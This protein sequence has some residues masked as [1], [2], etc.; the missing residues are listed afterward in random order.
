MKKFLIM[1]ILAAGFASAQEMKE[2]VLDIDAFIAGGK[3]I[4]KSKKPITGVVKEYYEGGKTAYEISI[5]N[6][7]KEG[8]EKL[9]YE[10]GRLQ[11]ETPYKNGKRDGV[12]KWFTEAGQVA[13]EI[14]YKND[15]KDGIEKWYGANGGLEHE[16]SYKS[17]WKNGVE[18]YYDQNGSIKQETTFKNN[19]RSGLEKTYLPNGAMLEIRF[20]N[21]IGVSGFCVGVSG[22]RAALSKEEIFELDYYDTYIDCK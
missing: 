2:Y 9:Y 13:Q 11:Q 8:V 10:N 17:D 14:P 12:E 3:V 5:K 19:V 4:D 1:L 18:R 22:E 21:N 20:D 15:K 16:I 6:G 7:K